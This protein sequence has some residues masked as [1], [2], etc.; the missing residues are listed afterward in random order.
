MNNHEENNNIKEPKIEL[1]E[2]TTINIKIEKPILSFDCSD[3]KSK[4]MISFTGTLSGPYLNGIVL[5]GGIDSQTI[6]ENKVNRLS[7]RYMVELDNGD[8]VF[9]EN[10]G[11]SYT[12]DNKTYFKCVPKFMTNSKKYW[13][14][15]TDIFVAS[16]EGTEDGVEI[17]VYRCV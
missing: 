10:N 15:N 13:W 12:K 6:D 16:A 4:A 3:G 1:E 17:T 14:L 2:I 8:R 7:A 11:V 5:P 9:I